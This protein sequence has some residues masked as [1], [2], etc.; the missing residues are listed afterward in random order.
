MIST[1]SQ[2]IDR[3]LNATCRQIDVSRKL[4]RQFQHPPT[5]PAVKCEIPITSKRR[6][7]AIER[8]VCLGIQ[9]NKKYSNVKT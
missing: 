8:D 1:Y 4:N 6:K 7:L 5:L 3:I 9:G 2:L